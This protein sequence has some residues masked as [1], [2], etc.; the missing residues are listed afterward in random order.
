M[1]A[2]PRAWQDAP[3]LKIPEVGQGWGN[4]LTETSSTKVCHR[5]SGWWDSHPKLEDSMH[6]S[7]HDVQIRVVV[8]ATD[9]PSFLN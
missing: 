8:I 9:F 2:L 6:T 5:Q 1:D 7:N 3:K 4:G